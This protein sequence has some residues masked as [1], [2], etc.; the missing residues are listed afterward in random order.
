MYGRRHR[1]CI[2]CGRLQ[3][4]LI[5]VL[6]RWLLF[7][8]RDDGRDALKIYTDPDYFFN[9]WRDAI[10]KEMKDA[11]EKR[12]EHKRKTVR[13]FPFSLCGLKDDFSSIIAFFDLS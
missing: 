10:R 11:K 7:L 9:L 13:K 3:G 4:L 8:F 12:K 2:N 6:N 1:I 5:L